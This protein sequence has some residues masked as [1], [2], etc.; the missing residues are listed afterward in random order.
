MSKQKVVGYCNHCAR[1]LRV[2]DI[3]VMIVGAS[4]QWCRRFE[5]KEDAKRWHDEFLKQNPTESIPNE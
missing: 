2:E 4:G 3:G 1:L 5:C